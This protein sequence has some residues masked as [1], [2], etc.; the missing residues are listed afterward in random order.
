MAAVDDT[1]E[2]PLSATPGSISW[3]MHGAGRPS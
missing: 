3:T 2:L 1:A